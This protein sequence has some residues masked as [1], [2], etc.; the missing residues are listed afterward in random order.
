MSANNAE[1]FDLLENILTAIRNAAN[2]NTLTFL[3]NNFKLA[4]LPV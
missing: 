2:G 3:E 4:N 1:N